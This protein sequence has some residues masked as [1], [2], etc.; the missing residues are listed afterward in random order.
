MQIRGSYYNRLIYSA[1][2]TDT[3]AKT[4]DTA[5]I[6]GY[7][8]KS[9]IVK[10][11]LNQN[12][13][14]QIQGSCDNITFINVGATTTVNAGV[15]SIIGVNEVAQLNNYFPF[16]RATITASISPTTGTITVQAVAM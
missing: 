10:N 11:G 6:S 13:V 2:I 15:N 3:N 1:A 16:L 12:A 8:E 14:I 9:L 4:S 5:E 7:S